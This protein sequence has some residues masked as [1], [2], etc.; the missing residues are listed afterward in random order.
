MQ[1][2]YFSNFLK[3]Y[4]KYS[5]KYKKIYFKNYQKYS[6]K[7]KKIFFLNYQKNSIKCKKIFFLNYEK[8]LIKYK[9]VFKSIM[10]K[11]I[12]KLQKIFN[13]L[14]KIF[15]KIAKKYFVK[16]LKIK[17]FSEIKKTKINEDNSQKILYETKQ[18]IVFFIRLFHFSKGSTDHK[19]FSS[20]RILNPILISP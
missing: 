13:K 1:K 5:T 18:F 7:C 10:L 6:T 19:M 4:E 11:N 3:F 17:I 8:H 15:N 12:T 9:K 2:R 16:L 20:I 14:Q